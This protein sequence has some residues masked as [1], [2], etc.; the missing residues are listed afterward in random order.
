MSDEI[1]LVTD[2][3]RLTI[4]PIKYNDI[5]EM[6]KKHEAAMW[7][8]HEVELDKDIKDWND[9]L[10]NNERHFIKYVLAFF[11]SSDIIVSQ[12]LSQRFLNEIQLEEAKSF[13]KFQ[14]M[15]ETIHS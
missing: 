11:A 8:S 1:L 9:K 3:D 15:I 10:D 14:N 6:Y 5:W 13:Y 4:K 7:H 2:P 12:N